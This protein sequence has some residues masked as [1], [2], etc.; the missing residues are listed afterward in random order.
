VCLESP[1]NVGRGDK[2]DGNPSVSGCMNELMHRPVLE[3]K[4]QQEHH[5]AQSVEGDS[6]RHLAI[7]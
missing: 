2:S 1:S 6:W 5:D 3:D 7:S 4:A